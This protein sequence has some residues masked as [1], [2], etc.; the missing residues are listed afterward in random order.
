MFY[1]PNLLWL[2]LSRREATFRNRPQALWGRNSTPLSHVHTFVCLMTHTTCVPCVEVCTRDDNCHFC[3]GWSDIEWS[4]YE[5]NLQKKENRKQKKLDKIQC[6]S[7]SSEDSLAV[8][9]EE[10]EDTAA[11]ESEM[12]SGSVKSVVARVSTKRITAPWDS[13][14]EPSPAPAK[15]SQR[16]RDMRNEDQNHH[17]DRGRDDL[18]R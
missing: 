11:E 17:S 14:H 16:D 4:L 5:R 10:S 9:P 1:C 3:L 8:N 18:R 6:E 12:E 15:R 13:D 7:V 2:R